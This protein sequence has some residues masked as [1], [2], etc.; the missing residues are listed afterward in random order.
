MET[1]ISVYLQ[2]TCKMP[3]LPQN[4]TETPKRP[5][6]LLFFFFFVG[7]HRKPSLASSLY[8]LKK[9]TASYTAINLTHNSQNLHRVSKATQEG[10][11]RN[12]SHGCFSHSAHG[13]DSLCGQSILEFRS[14]DEVVLAY[15]PSKFSLPQGTTCWRRG[16]TVTALTFS[17]DGNTAR[18]TFNIMKSWVQT[19]YIQ[20]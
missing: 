5:C 10:H 12:P 15:T 18:Q 2:S 16:S 7:S 17:W 20:I 8:K 4:Y 1:T 9:R 3:T 19:S 6:I 11:N 14:Q 13:L